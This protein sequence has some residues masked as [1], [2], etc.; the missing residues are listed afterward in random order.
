MAFALYGA[1]LVAASGCASS[2]APQASTPPILQPVPTPMPTPVVELRPLQDEAPAQSAP[3]PEAGATPTPAPQRGP[4]FIA[5]LLPTQSKAWRAAAETI[6]AGAMSAER[7]LAA[8]GTPP[9]RTIDTSDN[10]QDILAAF[11]RAQAEGAVAVIGPLTKTA[12]A[13]VADNAQFDFPVIALNSFSEET[14]RRPH[15]YSFSLSVEA[16]AQQAAR[17][18][19]E[20]GVNRPVVILGDGV[21]ARRMGQGFIDGWRADRNAAPSTLTV[22]GTDYAGLR[23][24]LDAS[25]AD[26]IFLATDTRAARRIRPFL[27]NMLP[28]F[29]TSQIDPGGLGATTLVDLAGI[30]FLDIPWLADPDN[31]TYDFY[32]R[33]R[34]KSNDLER[35]FAL[36]VDAWRLAIVLRDTQPAAVRIDDGLTGRLTI[37]ADGVVQRTLVPRTLTAA[38]ADAVPEAPPV[39]PLPQ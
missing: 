36:G 27:G 13:Y 34:G 37:G 35:L 6:R 16:E 26:G 4:A 24:Q 12:V 8:P 29:A 7:T 9:L 15:L 5:L 21:L 20:Q 38:R 33:A 2:P 39:E 17:F 11:Q 14:L 18:V 30:R 3:L 23:A 31:P 10:E 28:V 25:G 1:V 22:E 19:A 32:K